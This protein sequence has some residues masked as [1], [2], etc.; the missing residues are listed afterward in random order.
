MKYEYR[1]GRN[2]I[3]FRELVLLCQRMDDPPHVRL[4]FVD[5]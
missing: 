1:I 4:C 2:T 3:G 5:V